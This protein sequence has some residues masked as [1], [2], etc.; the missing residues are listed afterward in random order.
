[1][2]HRILFSL[3][4]LA[5]LALSSHAE[6]KKAVL[7]E[8]HFA[9]L[10]SYCLDCHDAASEKGGINLE[11][12]SFELSTVQSAETWQ[13]VLNS[14]N[15][16]DMPPKKKPQLTFDEKSEL[17]SDLSHQLVVARDV[18]SDSG[19]VITMRRLNK[20]EYE[21]T[22]EDLLG[23]RIEAD[24]LPDDANSDGFDTAGSALF[25]SSDQFEQYLDLAHKALDAAFVFG[26]Q[27]EPQTLKRESETSLNKFYIKQSNKLKEDYDKAQEWRATK[28]KKKP[29]DFGFIDEND[30]KFHERLYNQQYA[31][32][33]HYLSLPETKD[34]VILYRLFNGAVI[35]KF[36][37][38]NKWPA[39][40]YNVT[41]RAAILPGSKSHEQFL[42]YGWTG[43]GGRGGELTLLGCVRVTGTMEKPQEITLPITVPRQGSRTLA[44]R[45]RQHN[46]RDATRAAFVQSINRTGLGP[47]PALWVD[48]IS[49]T[50]PHY[51]QWPRPVV[52]K[53]FGKQMWW[54]VEDED[55]YARDIVARF[56]R[57]AFRT[58]TPEP[59]YIDKLHQLYLDAKAGGATF[60]VA[61]K[62]PL[63]VVMASPGFL[64]L[65]EPVTGEPVT[66]E[67]D[68]ESKK[69]HLLD[70]REFA[71]R[72]AYF[73]WSSPPDNI[74]RS[75]ASKGKLKDPKSL[76]WH[77]NR[78]LDDPRSDQF[79]AA[80]AHQWLD[81]ERLDFFQFDYA[82]YPEFDDSV[83]EAARNEVYQ[84][85][86][87][88][89]TK[90]RPLSDLL[91][92]DYA[93]VN[94]ILAD[95]YDIKGVTG[96]DFQR[97]SLPADSPRGGLLGMAAIHAMGSDGNHSSLVE[98][99]AW[100]MR[101]LLHNPPPPAPPNVPQLSRITNQ[102]LTPREKLSA[103]MEEAQCANCHSK[104]DPIG[105]GLQ[106][107]DAAGQ[108]RDDLLLEQV[109]KK[110]VKKKKTV[111]VDAAG[112]LPDGTEFADYH[113]L[114]DAVA[115]HDQAFSRSFT[116]A[117]IEYALGRKYGFSDE[118]LREKII[119]RADQKNG[120]MREHIIALI[121]SKAF[122]TKK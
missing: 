115:A 12:L 28:G 72:L 111:P 19:G 13:K 55:A 106:N 122:R 63:A 10:E 27:P 38:P 11:D 14:L 64:Y 5:T 1:M 15:S 18:L 117:L 119:N 70:E 35:D 33:A 100:V 88:I 76:A 41:V 26:K 6:E 116:E 74:L 37:F 118:A 16:G 71:V 23:V 7:P 21:N 46:N 47:K 80:F 57:R 84:T 52:S 112:T 73:L 82:A 85:I 58:R 43:G 108:W 62:E 42:E 45:Q 66:G 31:T 54:Q 60:Q 53:V 51:D 68:A 77:V 2:A 110:K 25:F 29:S 94:D 34:G 30:V 9:I 99:G 61:I 87:H 114:R 69:P 105:Y 48:W 92:A 121:Q 20:R 90:D 104:I 96:S 113:G 98:R 93:V 75:A 4:L 103:H 83:K 44:F 89:L 36:E 59:E 109:V 17:L 39:E 78:M 107:F 120:Q 86:R 91:K 81:M 95:Y 22:V 8:K 3:G 102:L 32:Y 79:I 24:A 97:V 49:A 56:A 50:G 67:P 65:I 40:E 101:K